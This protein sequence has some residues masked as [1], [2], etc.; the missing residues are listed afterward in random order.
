MQAIIEE[1]SGSPDI[2]AL[3]GVDMLVIGDDGVLVRVRA[4]RPHGTRGCRR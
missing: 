2:L 4:L 3:R 1:R